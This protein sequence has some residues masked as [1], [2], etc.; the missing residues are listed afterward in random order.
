MSADELPFVRQVLKIAWEGN[1]YYFKIPTN[2]SLE[3]PYETIHNIYFMTNIKKLFIDIID[4]FEN[5]TGFVGEFFIR[6]CQIIKN[7]KPS[8]KDGELEEIR[9]KNIIASFG[10]DGY[11]ALTFY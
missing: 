10:E 8:S 5:G 7:D 9:D 2:A 1:D 6:P 3:Y 4:D 11:E